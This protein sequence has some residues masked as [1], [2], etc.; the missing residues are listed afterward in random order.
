MA[1]YIALQNKCIN[2]ILSMMIFKSGIPAHDI[3]HHKKCETFSFKVAPK[4]FLLIY[5][6][7]CK[8]HVII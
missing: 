8:I 3:G 4:H 2:I 5:V 7:H 1:L 6:H